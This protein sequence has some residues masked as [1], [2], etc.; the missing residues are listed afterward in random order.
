MK[1]YLFAVLVIIVMALPSKAFAYISANIIVI[2]NTG[3]DMVIEKVEGGNLKEIGRAVPGKEIVFGVRLDDLIIL[4]HGR[5]SAT[6]LVKTYY[7]G[8][9]KYYG[10]GPSI[11]LI[12]ERYGSRTFYSQTTTTTIRGTRVRRSS[13]RGPRVY[14]HP[15]GWY[16]RGRSNYYGGRRH[17]DTIIEYIGDGV[18]PAP[19]ILHNENIRPAVLS[20]EEDE[21]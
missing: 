20:V 5:R 2:N 4:G 1:K 18:D 7:P 16:E 9:D 10:S 6:Y 17:S 14:N 13:S 15:P 3:L 21:Y 11:L 19:I 8:T 12:R